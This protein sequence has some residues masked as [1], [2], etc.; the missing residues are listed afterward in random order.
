MA[1][2]I[3][4]VALVAAMRTRISLREAMALLRSCLGER[5][6]RRRSCQAKVTLSE[7]FGITIDRALE[8]GHGR[9]RKVASLADI[10]QDVGVLAAQQRQQPV[11]ESAHPVD[12]QR[13]EIAVDAGIDDNRLLFHLERRELRLLEE[14]GQPG[15]AI[16]QALSGGIEVGAEL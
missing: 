11:L 1:L 12:R 14:F 6:V 10:F 3:F 2:V 15:A 5:L 8:L 16:K 7:G 4:C 13:I 9:V